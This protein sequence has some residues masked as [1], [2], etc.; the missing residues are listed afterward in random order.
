MINPPISPILTTTTTTMSA[1]PKTPPVSQFD[2]SD[3]KFINKT[4]PFIITTAVKP[5]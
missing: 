1:S 3:D 4:I 5:S 2:D